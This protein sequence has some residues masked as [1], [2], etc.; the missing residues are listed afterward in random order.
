MIDA[1]DNNEESTAVRKNSF[2]LPAIALSGLLGGA[3]FAV[4][5][6]LSLE[7]RA[8]QNQSTLE[9]VSPQ[10]ATQTENTEYYELNPI[11]ISLGT[12]S[13]IKQL[14]I[15]LYL[16]ITT[17]SREHV[18][19]HLPRIYDMLNAYL[20]AMSDSDLESSA[21]LLKLKLQMLRRVQLLLGEGVV[22]DILISRF[23]VN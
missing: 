23:L 16:E 17:G 22:E 19:S 6:L 21:S 18:T 1:M 15:E 11:Q 10:E 20:R 9:E 4:S 12:M 13:G 5:F 3:G 2:I 8:N 7:S 14:R